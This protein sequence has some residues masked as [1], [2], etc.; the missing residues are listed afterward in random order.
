MVRPF[1]AKMTRSELMAV[2]VGGFATVAG[3]VMAAYV[4]FGVDAGH[5]LS[6]SV[7]SAPAALVV[8]KIMFPETEE[9]VTAGEIKVPVDRP[10]APE[11]AEALVRD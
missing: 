10:D 7:M 8:A 5:L 2:M 11:L 6:A 1:V 4:R 9:P 3:G